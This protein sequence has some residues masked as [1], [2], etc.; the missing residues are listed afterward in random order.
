M[1]ES[2]WGRWSSTANAHIRDSPARS[3]LSEK[4]R[5]LGHQFPQ[6]G[7]EPACGPKRA[8]VKGQ[9]AAR[10]PCAAAPERG[11]PDGMN[12]SAQQR[13]GEPAGF[14]HVD[15]ARIALFQCGHDL[16]HVLGPGGP[17]LCD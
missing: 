13:F 4:N 10:E 7:R 17:D 1:A 15:L 5:T 8:G 14:A 2:A 16:A 3:F 12:R 9:G 6:P 11:A